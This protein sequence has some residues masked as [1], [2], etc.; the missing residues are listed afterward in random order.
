[1]TGGGSASAAAAITEATDARSLWLGS[2]TRIPRRGT[3]HGTLFG[4][5]TSSRP[6][7][8]A[9]LLGSTPFV[10]DPFWLRLGLSPL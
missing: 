10:M 8:L 6:V 9:G 2:S 4:G 1:M 3:C 5:S 7:S